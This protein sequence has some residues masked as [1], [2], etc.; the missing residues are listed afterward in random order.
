MVCHSY[1]P[2]PTNDQITTIIPALLH[3]AVLNQCHDSPSAGHLGA[4]K[5]LDQFRQLGYWVNMI[6]DVETYCRKCSACQA[7][8]PPPPQ[9]VPLTSVP[10]GKPWQMVAVDVLEVPRSPKN[11]RYLL[12]AQDYFTK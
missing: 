5:T 6:T 10:I 7:T 1:A 12:V 11:N 9:R 8:K 4:D 3:K 2:S